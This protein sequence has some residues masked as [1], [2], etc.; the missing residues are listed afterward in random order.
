LRGPGF[1]WR[2]IVHRARS[3]GGPQLGKG[4]L[5]PCSGIWPCVNSSYVNEHARHRYIYP[6][7]FGWHIA[8][9]MLLKWERIGPQAAFDIIDMMTAKLKMIITVNRSEIDLGYLACAHSIPVLTTFI[10]KICTRLL[11]K[12][13]RPL[14]SQD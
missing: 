14:F 1:C 8:E 12:W 6:H 4:A 10:A 7:D 9:Q 5:H 3:T 11:T 13:D 2:W